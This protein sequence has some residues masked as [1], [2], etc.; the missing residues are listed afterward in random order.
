MRDKQGVLRGK[1]TVCGCTE[2]NSSNGKV[3]C[4][5]CDH[6]P[7]K[8]EKI[9]EATAENY[10]WDSDDTSNCE[11]QWENVL[12][13]T[14]FSDSGTSVQHFT[15]QPT[16]ITQAWND[17]AGMPEDASSDDYFTAAL[18]Q[19][20]GCGA[21]VNFDLNTRQYNSPYCHHH[22]SSITPLNGCNNTPTLHS[23]S[24]GKTCGYP[25]CGNP[26]YMEHNGTVHDYCRRS[27]AMAMPVQLVPTASTTPIPTVAGVS[28]CAI[29]ECTNPCFVDGEGK[30]F[31]C[32]GYTHAME[33]Q[34]RKALAEAPSVKGIT[35]CLLPECSNPVWPFMNYCGKS[36]ADLGKQQGLQPPLPQN[37]QSDKPTNSCILPGCRQPKHVDPDGTVHPYCGRTHSQQA[38]NL[39]IFPTT[40][41]DSDQ[42][43][44][45]GCSRPKRKE[46]DGTIHDYCSRDHAVQDIPNRDARML[47]SR[48]DVDKYLKKFSN[49]TVLNVE[50]NPYAKPGG[51]L[52]NKFKSK[53]SSLPKHQR[54]TQLAFHGTPEAN[55]QSICA[56]GFDSS[57]RR[58]QALGPGE[59]FAV[60]P[61]TPMGYCGGGRKLLLNELL[62]GQQGT[63][64]TRHGDIIVMKD[65]AHDLPRFV[66][67]F[68]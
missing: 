66:I 2:Y 64:H 23:V 21:V 48:R 7:A 35:H 68:R 51:A 63:H 17:G 9:T 8:H 59:Y 25:G 6:V 38:K 56:N 29:P 60:S 16:D 39:G 14:T 53:Y 32:C 45:A 47:T 58:G 1:C 37:D 30:A 10:C 22:L 4:E 42:C 26:C 62:L 15:T 3:R 27:H 43:D 13:L 5:D 54:T 20:P 24:S 55:I 12:N 61:D 65:P 36:H 41:Q 40:D 52:F 31:E 28:K 57:R 46:P 49:L 34:R 11:D 19:V 50:E 67:T 44:L 18:C 33:L